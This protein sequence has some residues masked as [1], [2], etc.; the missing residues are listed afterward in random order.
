MNTTLA[1]RLHIATV[2]VAVILLL[3]PIFNGVPSEQFTGMAIATLFWLAVYYFFFTYMATNFMLP[4]K[5]LSFFAGSIVIIALLPFMG[6]T[7]LFLSR[8]IFRGDFSNLFQDY[9][10]GVHFSGLKAMALAG[11]Y[12]SFFRLMTEFFRK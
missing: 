6:Y 5:L 8:A 2:S 7:L 4:G 1:N 11:V 9:S 3:L 12:G 10:F